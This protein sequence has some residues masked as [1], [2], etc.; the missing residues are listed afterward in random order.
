MK[1]KSLISIKTILCLGLLIG[2]FSCKKSGDTPKGDPVNSAENNAFAEAQYNDVNIMV[3]QAGASSTITFSQVQ[4]YDGQVET[5]GILGSSCATVSVDTNANPH[6]ITIDFGSSNCLCL[7]NRN[8][9]GKILATY[10]GQFGRVGTEINVGFEGYYVNDYGIS[11][12][13]TITN[14]G[15]N[16]GGN[17]VYKVEVDGMITKPGDGGEFTW[18]STR[19]RE[20]KSGWNTPLTILDDEYAITGSASGTN[21]DGSSYS[22]VI[23]TE[24]VRKMNCRWFESGVLAFTQAGYPTISLDYGNSGC[25]ANASLSVLGI[26]YPISLK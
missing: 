1:C 10:T 5:L 7:D 24:L 21:P 4:P 17:P 19:F 13:K 26:T 23:G 22:V 18:V 11:G 2:S 3:D 14:M 25:D 16:N 9:R 6:L 15:N 12:T 20:W 8:R